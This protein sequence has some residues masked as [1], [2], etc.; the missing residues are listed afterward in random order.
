LFLLKDKI[1]ITHAVALITLLIWVATFH[2]VYCSI[3]AVVAV[4]VLVIWLAYLPINFLKKITT[5]GDYS[6]GIYI[7]GFP[8]QQI[9][10]HCTK[11]CIGIYPLI[12]YSLIG[13][14]TIAILSFHFIEQPFL[15]RKT[16]ARK[17]NL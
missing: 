2:S 7:F 9:I 14:I 17:I 13:S 1:K 10:I 11:G 16:K 8:I 6:Y 4:P 15:M 3:F 5:T 12:I